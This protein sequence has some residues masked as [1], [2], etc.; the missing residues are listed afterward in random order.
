MPKDIPFTVIENRLAAEG[1]YVIRLRSNEAITIPSAGQFAM[2]KIGSGAHPLLRRPFSY[3]GITNSEIHFIYKVVGKGTRILSRVKKEEQ[4]KVLGPLGK[5][6]DLSLAKKKALLVGGGMGFAPLLYLA[7]ALTK[8]NNLAVELIV[9]T[10]SAS[11]LPSDFISNRVAPSVQVSFATEDGSIGYRGMVS[12]LLVDIFS[13]RQNYDVI[14]SCGPMP[15][16]KVISQIA[17]THRLPCE[18][19]VEA[20]MACGVG[21]CM[22]CVVPGGEGEYLRACTDGP[23]FKAEELF[24]KECNA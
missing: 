1:I 16:L 22:G 20:L 8:K 19:S 2:V 9:G 3:A 6:F 18:V 17:Q 15:M 4:L 14:Y 10:K 7:S 24:G 21:A 12:D 13:K 11:F 23:V 5:G